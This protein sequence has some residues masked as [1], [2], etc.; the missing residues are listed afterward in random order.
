MSMSFAWFN[1][2]FDR[3]LRSNHV[4]RQNRAESLG[5]VPDWVFLADRVRMEYI[6]FEV[7]IGLSVTDR[8]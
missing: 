2:L 4:S 7:F 6:S 3:I 5:R 8:V 1:L